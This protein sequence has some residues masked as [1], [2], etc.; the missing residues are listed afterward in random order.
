M[1]NVLLTFLIIVPCLL[2]SQTLDD[3]DKYSKSMNF[4]YNIPS[5]CKTV[6]KVEQEDVSYLIAFKNTDNIEYRI[7]AYDK[8]N[9]PPNLLKSSDSKKIEETLYMMTYTVAINI[10]QDD[11]IKPN[12]KFFEHNEVKKEF[13]GDYGTTCFIKGNSDFSKGYTYII[14]NSIYKKGRGVIFTF[15]LMNDVKKYIADANN[16]KNDSEYYCVKFN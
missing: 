13:G 2:Y 9:L 15:I 16:E 5:W 1:K 7:S 6:P 8:N 3:I 11:T 10:A 12:I 14:I 4:K